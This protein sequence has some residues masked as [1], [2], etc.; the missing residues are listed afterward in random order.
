[1][2]LGPG[3]VG[4]GGLKVLHLWHHSQKTRTP[5]QKTFC[6]CRLEDLLHLLNSSL[7]L[8]AP[9]LRMQS[10]VQ[11]GCFGAR[12]LNSGPMPKC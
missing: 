2:G 5:K 9:K 10:H 12:I 1:L 11:S 4:Q 8:L 6:K 3:E 7:P